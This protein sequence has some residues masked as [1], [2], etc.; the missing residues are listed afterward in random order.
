MGFANDNSNLGRSYYEQSY[1]LVMKHLFLLFLWFILIAQS[2]SG[3]IA[4]FT[5]KS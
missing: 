4:C 1:T 2:L 3:D 5:N